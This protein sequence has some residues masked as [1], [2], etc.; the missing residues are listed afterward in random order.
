MGTSRPI[1]VIAGPTASGKSDLAVTLAERF[2]GEIICADSRTVYRHLDIGTAKPSDADT[3]K[4]AHHGLDLIEPSEEFSAYDFKTYALGKIKDIL[5]RGKVPF[6]VGGSG[7]Y[8]DGLV[9][10]FDFA[11]KPDKSTRERLASLSL[12]ELQQIAQNSGIRL[13]ESDGKNARYIARAIERQGY[14]MSKKSLA[15][16]VL[17]MAVSA[18]KDKL[19]NRIKKRVDM[20]I[21]NGFINEAIAAIEQFGDKAPGL[22]APGYKAVAAQMNNKIDFSEVAERFARNDFML[23]KRQ[24]T[25]L[26]R[27]KDV[28]WVDNFADA[29]KIIKK[30]LAEFDT[31]AS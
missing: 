7:L 29:E 6:I 8:I 12:F 20:M 19:R 13:N 28:I 15:Q 30:F 9:Y 27:N 22:Q 31:I 10:D 17:Y 4:V 18:D 16:N 24:M 5:A 23:A 2:K 14:Q 3:R 11:A 21:K 1:I 26:R 25:W